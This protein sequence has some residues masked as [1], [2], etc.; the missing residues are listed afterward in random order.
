MQAKPIQP[1]DLYYMD[2]VESEEGHLT[3]KMSHFLS[4]FNFSLDIFFI[5]FK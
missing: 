3:Q 5:R 2:G 4:V 1:Q